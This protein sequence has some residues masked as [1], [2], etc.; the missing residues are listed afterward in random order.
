MGRMKTVNNYS[1]EKINIINKI[2]SKKILTESEIKE[3]ITVENIEDFINCNLLNILKFNGV[4]IYYL[5]SNACKLVDKP[6]LN[7]NLITDELKKYKPS[8]ADIELFKA[9]AFC[10]L[11]TLTKA[12]NYFPQANIDKCFL[13]EFII[14]DTN[15]GEILLHLTEKSKDLLLKENYTY[16]R[17]N[18]RLP[19]ADYLIDNYT[20]LS[21]ETQ[22][23]YFLS[24]PSV[25]DLSNFKNLCL[26]GDYIILDIESVCYSSYKNPKILEI[27]A[28][29]VKNGVISEKFNKLIKNDDNHIPKAIIEL[30]GI[31]PNMINNGISLQS[32]LSELLIFIENLPILAHGIENDWHGYILNS[33]YRYKIFIPNN[34]ILDTYKMINCQQNSRKNGLDALVT[35]FEIDTSSLPRHR[36]LNDAIITY[37]V[38][39]KFCNQKKRIPYNQ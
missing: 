34:R 37:L 31:T 12:R 6:Y 5:N 32:A 18:H 19:L 14:K 17:K 10:G 8:Y 23:D 16:I 11:I 20:N 2:Y 30:T 39:T 28:V 35:R 22:N 27:A 21:K 3:I 36:A 38:L 29:K 24:Y 13:S 15:K 9:I 1:T 7:F 25:T 4:N 26:N 33:L